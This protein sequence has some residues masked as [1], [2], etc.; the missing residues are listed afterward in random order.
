[1]KSY[2]VVAPHFVAGFVARSETAFWAAPI[3]LRHLAGKT[4][5]QFL[6]YATKRGWTVEEHS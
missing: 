6:A 1:M 4:L 2:R 3:L 5:K